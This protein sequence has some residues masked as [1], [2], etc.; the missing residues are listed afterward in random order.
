MN[1]APDYIAAAKKLA[2]W[3]LHRAH[4]GRVLSDP[5]E[6]ESV[7]LFAVGR[8][9]VMHDPTRCSWASFLYNYGILT[10]LAELRRSRYNQHGSMIRKHG[11]REEHLLWDTNRFAERPAS[12]QHEA[13]VERADEVEYFLSLLS[14]PQARRIMRR[15]HLDE[16]MI[17]DIAKEEG[18]SRYGVRLILARAMDRIRRKVSAA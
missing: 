12:G 3:Y 6:I 5:E 2:Y 8:L 7:A 16:M 18:L 13:V 9:A 4:G 15:R 17:R 11:A 10:V 14:S 1:K